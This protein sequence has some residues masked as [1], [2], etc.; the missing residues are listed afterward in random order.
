MHDYLGHPGINKMI[1]TIGRLFKVPSLRS[2]VQL[3]NRAC[4]PCAKNKHY[5]VKTG[6]VTGF[7]EAEC[8]GDKL[9]S[10]LYGPIDLAEY[11]GTGKVFI[12]TAIDVF[13][14]FSIARVL[15]E[16]TS[17]EV[18]RTLQTQWFDVY[19]KP[20]Q[21]LTDNGR[22]YTGKH[23]TDL[24]RRN[25]IKH[26]FSTPYNPTGNSIA[27]RINSTMGHILRINK[28]KRI[29]DVLRTV[30]TFWNMTVHRTLGVTPEEVF[31]GHHSLDILKI[32]K[33]PRLRLIRERIEK[34]AA[35]TRKEN[36][37]HRKAHEWKEGQK[38]LVRNRNKNKL[39]DIWNGPYTIVEVA[40]GKNSVL[41]ED[42]Y[43]T[44]W[45]NI[46]HLKILQP[47]E[48]PGLTTEEVGDIERRQDDRSSLVDSCPRFVNYQELLSNNN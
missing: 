40:R 15:E 12:I 8:P 4:I 32:C 38:V 10:D 44:F 37:E 41:L 27:E 24:C 47:Q 46:K 26:S 23:F 45:E 20:K 2:R 18:V 36:N 39:D 9:A 30:E 7:I 11:G 19:G 33:R 6:K 42:E 1:S 21:V 17:R 43:K 14:R 35:I 29:E 22:Q 3:L 25:K 16:P 5:V 48:E 13:S 31:L 28:G 34:A